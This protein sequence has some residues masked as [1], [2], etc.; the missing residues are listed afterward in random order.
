MR[1]IEEIAYPSEGVTLAMEIEKI[2]GDALDT[3]VE[4]SGAFVI[5]GQSRKEFCEKLGKLI[6]EYRI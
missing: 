3:S 4:L 1:K 2:D 5:C 6:D